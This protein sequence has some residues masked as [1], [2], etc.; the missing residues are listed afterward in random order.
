METHGV[1]LGRR[2]GSVGVK[3]GL[4]T[5]PQVMMEELLEVLPRPREADLSGQHSRSI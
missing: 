1:S 2:P 5:H 4:V 3:E